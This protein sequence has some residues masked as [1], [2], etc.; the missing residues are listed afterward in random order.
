MLGTGIGLLELQCLRQGQW[1]T[2]W[3]RFGSQGEDWLLAKVTLPELSEMLRFVHSG[4]VSGDADVALDALLAWEPAA[5]PTS[6]LSMS[7][8]HSHSCALLHHQGLVKCWGFGGSGRLGYGSQAFAPGAAPNQMGAALPA[9]ELGPPEP[10]VRATQVACG[11]RHSCAVLETGH[12]KCWGDGHDGKVGPGHDDV[13]VGDEPFEMGVFLPA[14]DLGGSYV[15]Q[16]APGE[17]HTCA[18]LQGGV[19]KC[20]GKG[21]MLGL[22]DAMDRGENLEEMGT[23]LP[24]VDLGTGF[25]AVQLVAGSY[26]TCALSRQGAVK[27]WGWSGY[28]GL[29]LSENPGS[30]VGTGPGEMG[31]A[32]PALDLGDLPII[33]L[34]AGYLHTC[35]VRVDGAV[36]CWG[37]NFAGELGHGGTE[38]AGDDPGEMGNNL[39]TTDLGEGSRAVHIASGGYHTCAILR[40]AS[41]KCWGYG[42][43]GQLGQGNAQDLG[44]EPSEMGSALRA[45]DVGLHGV[46]GVTCGGYH[47]CVLLDDDSIRCWGG[48]DEG[49]L[50]QG[51]TVNVGNLQGQMGAALV[52][53]ELFVVLLGAGDGLE[54]LSLLPGP[55]GGSSSSGLLQLSHN[56]SL[57]LVCDD[58]FDEAAAQVACRDLGMAGGEAFSED[59]GAGSIMADNIKCTGQE[60]SLR[61]CRFRGWHVHDCSFREAAGIRCQLDAW[62]EY[63]TAGGP[64]G[65]QD[66]SMVWD[67]ETQSALLFGGH[68][69]NAFL[70]FEDLWRYDWLQRAWREIRPSGPKPSTRSGHAAVWD[71]RSRSMIIFAGRFLATFYDD[72][73]QYVEDGSWKQFQIVGALQAPQARAYHTAILDT[74]ENALLAFGGESSQVLGDLWRYSLVERQW[75]QSLATG[76]KP[77]ARSRHGAAWAALTRQM[78]VFAGWSGDQYLEDLHYYDSSADRWGEVPAA[79]HWPAPRSGHATAWDPVS[80]SMLVMGGTQN[81]SDGLSYSNSLYNFSLLGGFWHEEG[82]QAGVPGPSGRAAL[83]MVWDEKSRGLFAFGGFNASYLQQSWRY[84]VSQTDPPLVVRCDLGSNC[85]FLFRNALGIGVKHVCSDSDFLDGQLFVVSE[86]AN[87]WS[88]ESS[89]LL[90]EPGPH[91]L[92]ACEG[93]CSHPGDY[94]LAIGY[95]LV[96]G[97]YSDQSAQCYLGSVC[98]INAWRGFGISVND[99]VVMQ[100]RCMNGE[101]SINYPWERAIGVTFNDTYGWHSLQVGLLDHS[102]GKPE[103]VEL[104]WCP[105]SSAC[106][107]TADF[108]VVALR[109]EIL[110]PPG[111]Y[112]G[113][114]QSCLLCPADHF[115]PGGGVELQSCPVASTSQP[116]SRELSDC[117]CLRGHYW[118]GSACLLCPAGSSTSQDGATSLDSCTCMAGFVNTQPDNPAACEACGVGFFCPGGSQSRQPCGSFQTTAGEMSPDPSHCVCEAGRFLDGGTCTLCPVG[119]FKTNIGDFSCTQCGAGTSHGNITGRVEPCKCRPGYGF[120]ETSAQCTVCPPGEYKSTVGY[121]CPG[122]GEERQCPDGATSRARSEQQADCSCLPG[123][124]FRPDSTCGPCPEGFYKES[125]GNDAFCPRQCPTNSNSTAGSNSPLNCFCDSGYYP[126]VHSSGFI[127]RCIDCSILPNMVCLGGLQDSRLLNE[128]GSHSLPVAKDGFFQTGKAIAIKCRVR[129][130]EGDSACMGSQPIRDP[131]QSG[132]IASECTGLDGLGNRC[133]AG[134]RGMLC[135]ECPVGWARNSFQAPCQQCQSS[136]LTLAFSLLFDIFSKAAL[137]FIVASMAATAAVRGS[138]KLHTSMIRIAIQWFAACSVI[139]V[140]DLDQLRGLAFELAYGAGPAAVLPW[141]PWVQDAIRDLLGFFS[142]VQLQLSVQF[143]LHCVAEAA[144]PS[145]QPSQAQNEALAIYFLCLP[146]FT[147]VA[148]VTLCALAVYVLVPLAKLRGFSFN[149]VDKRRWAKLKVMQKLKDALEPTLQACDLSW[150]D[151]ENSGMLEVSLTSLQEALADASMFLQRGAAASPQFLLR[152]LRREACELGFGDVAA[153]RQLVLGAAQDALQ[154]EEERGP[155]EDFKRFLARALGL[156]LERL[157]TEHREEDLDMDAEMD[158]L[159]F[160]LFHAKPNLRVL[161]YQSMPVVWIGLSMAWPVLLSGFLRL[162]WCVPIPEGD[163]MPTLRLLPSPD[164]I[165]SSDAHELTATLALT[166]LL[167]WCLGIPLALFLRVLALRDRHAPETYRRYGYFIQGYEPQFWYWEL[168]VKR[169]DVGLVMLFTYTAVVPDAEAKLLLLP[170]LSGFQTITTAWLKPYANSQNQIL[171]FVDVYLGTVRFILFS[172]IAALLILRP[173]ERPTHALAAFLLCMLLATITYLV[174]HV[175]VQ[176]LRHAAVDDHSS[177]SEGTELAKLSPLSG[178]SQGVGSF[179]RAALQFILLAFQPA[180]SENI[181]IKWSFEDAVISATA[182]PTEAGTATTRAAPRSKSW[183]SLRSLR[184]SVLRFGP[185]SQDKALLKANEEFTAFLL[186]ELGQRELPSESGKLL[187]VLAT[188]GR[189]LSTLAKTRVG[190]AWL[191][192]AV[193]T[194][195]EAGHGKVCAP[196]DLER[197]VARLRQMPGKD[198]HQLI[199]SVARLCAEH[200]VM[201][202]L[203][204]KGATLPDDPS[205]VLSSLRKT[206]LSEWTADEMVAQGVD[207]DADDTGQ[208]EDEVEEVAVEASC[209][210]E[211]DEVATP[212]RASQ[213]EDQLLEV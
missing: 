176:F 149:R 153:P 160:G 150:D 172:C 107:S 168:V 56:G 88:L 166:G 196:E 73:W 108:L 103:T 147:T 58:G 123:F 49:Q 7:F 206:L 75:S 50:G 125:E 194:M 193:L 77:A 143:S 25:E 86:E 84:A 138:G 195:D 173:G 190:K 82:L 62:S 171:D 115:C 181:R 43:Q 178:K 78:L 29:G 76:P 186:Q 208:L 191:E 94:Q 3:S 129:T 139:Q 114:G 95:F 81:A 134:S 148:T 59:A 89:D 6:Y 22:G 35:A 164:I 91:R 60:A 33:Q 40:D 24:T 45:V 201:A 184:A 140:F 161:I 19:V 145:S 46:R 2:L 197:A 189:N 102:A 199:F 157:E 183:L 198:A 204:R 159:D 203:V 8:G 63:T 85:S 92:C 32:L 133:A 110:C 146:L 79:G 65:R 10:R 34:A 141:P 23:Q 66:S 42:S 17:D 142:L 200:V 100:S 72:L 117:K 135:G 36:R 101:A 112:T 5:S 158:T 205:Q 170:L 96:Q 127:I 187:C 83:A 21:D 213:N 121:F 37:A 113:S 120:E 106:G 182:A 118:T 144:L 57:G 179:R 74:A 87:R 39:P 26:H 152:A 180:D 192:A 137:N 64:D 165:C 61:Y 47:T 163:G 51:S 212:Q 68:A 80:K 38:T 156:L 44:D 70:Y 105:S 30:Y 155:E 209:L 175:L 104:C 116:G 20:F 207:G 136:E 185:G 48:N 109:L 31:D 93:G 97:P 130:A 11:L 188:A 111:E 210:E 18:L 14:I 98:T 202:G 71:P 15:V 126:E 119:R 12:L 69:S 27:C 9:V 54:G 174:L 154:A 99:S 28:L 177:S 16:V 167:V 211:N 1:I 151:V 128:T 122:G 55:G 169:I 162:L 52:P 90:L 41:L 124:F 67:V 132:A 4:L 53:T 131:C 13:F